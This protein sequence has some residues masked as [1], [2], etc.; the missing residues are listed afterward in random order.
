MPITHSHAA[1]LHQWEWNW[2]NHKCEEQK[3][4][5]R[6]LLTFAMICVSM[7]VMGL[8]YKAMMIIDTQEVR[9]ELRNGEWLSWICSTRLNR[10]SCHWLCSMYEKGERCRQTFTWT[11]TMRQCVR[12]S[13]SPVMAQPVLVLGLGLEVRRMACALRLRGSQETVTSA[14]TWMTGYVFPNRYGDITPTVCFIW[15]K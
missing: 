12:C 7:S 13:A 14:W 1:G 3:Q 8:I 5:L 10:S 11:S 2:T 4:M 9:L 6:T 15:K